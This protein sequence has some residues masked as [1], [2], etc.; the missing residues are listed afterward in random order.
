MPAPTHLMLVNINVLGIGSM[1]QWAD[2]ERSLPFLD[3]VPS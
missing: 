1:R 2:T 3:T